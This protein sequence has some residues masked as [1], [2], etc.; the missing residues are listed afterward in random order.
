MKSCRAS[1]GREMETKVKRHQGEIGH[2]IDE[3][4]TLSLDEGSNTYRQAISRN[5]RGKKKPGGV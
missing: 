5:T 4:P 3:A 2:G 1:Q